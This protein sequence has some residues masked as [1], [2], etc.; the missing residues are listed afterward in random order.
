MRAVSRPHQRPRTKG[1]DERGVGYVKHNAIAGR[2]FESFAA[3]EAHLDHWVR[4]VAEVRVH[5]TTGEPPRRRFEPDEASRLKPITGIPAFL[6]GRDLVRRV[7]SDCAVEVDGNAY[8]VPW[9]LIGERVGVTVTGTD[10]R[11][12]HA[13]QQV[14]CHRLRAGRHGRIVDM[15]HFAGIIGGPLIAGANAAAR[16]PA[17]PLLRPL[18]EYEAAAGGS[19]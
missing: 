14:A 18:S 1:K 19:W 6:T 7:S 11:V 4:E 17:P 5:G 16:V 15:A 2:S 3:L 13:G 12:S 9:H 10:L 8:S